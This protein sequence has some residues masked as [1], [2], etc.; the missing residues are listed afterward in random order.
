M[1]IELRPAAF[2]PYQELLQYQQQLAAGEYGA[3][4][5]F[6]GSMR[7]FNQG[8]SV[9]KMWLEYYP[10][11]T[12]KHLQAIADEAMQK[13]DLLDLM[14]LHRVGDINP[15]DPIVLVAAWSAHRAAAFEAS[16]YLMEELK[17]RAPF[18]KQEQL[19][20]KKRWVDMNTPA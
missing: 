9:Q 12:E 3:T 11:M 8:D 2:E 13:W 20:S 6:V 14:L 7:D 15:A 1:L 18:W 5:V 10:G 16:R 17:S 19:D 4:A